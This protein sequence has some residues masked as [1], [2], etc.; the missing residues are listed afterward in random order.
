[1][2]ILDFPLRRVAQLLSVRVIFT[3]LLEL[4]DFEIYPDFFS[5]DEV[6]NSYQLRLVRAHSHWCELCQAE[7]SDTALQGWLIFYRGAVA[8]SNPFV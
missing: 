2:V 6:D 3:F 4:S 8:P 1:M 7:L 5:P